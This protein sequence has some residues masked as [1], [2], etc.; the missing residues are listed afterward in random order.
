MWRRIELKNYRSIESAR[1]DLAPFTVL[2]GPNGSGKSNFADALVFISELTD[3]SAAITRRGG[4]TG[5]RRWQRAPRGEV[6]LS[7]RVAAS[8]AALDNNYTQYDCVIEFDQGKSWKFA[9][10]SVDEVKD[11]ATVGTVSRGEDGIVQLSPP[12]PV[13]LPP[14]AP[15]AS[16]ALFLKQISILNSNK[17]MG[18]PA[19]GMRR[20]R[21][22]P[23]EMRKPYLGSDEVFLNESGSNIAEA[24]DHLRKRKDGSYEDVLE[25]MKRMVPGLVEID[26]PKAGH[27]WT[28]EFNQRQATGGVAPF[29]AMEMSDGALRALGILV[30][31]RQLE[32]QAVLIVEEPE[33]HLHPGA[34]AVLFEALKQASQRGAVLITTHSPEL[35]DAAKDE[36]LL[37]C[38]YR[39]G[40]TRVGP[41]DTEQRQ[42]VREGLFS[43]AELMRTTPL[44]IQG[45]APATLE[46]PTT[47]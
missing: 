29:T 36:E 5:L 25:S 34:T 26:T 42:I 44:R 32:P 18:I 3:A 2:V 35:L 1:V 10:E 24:I 14:L 4:I 9:S 47:P 38:D 15:Q 39:S 28:L 6:L 11:G 13:Q 33:V 43:A 17:P 37:V 31:A 40:V 22:N 12:Q 19:H 30:A 21:L 41:L 16:L 20:Y 46:P 45:D 27:Y 23:D 8:R 7:L